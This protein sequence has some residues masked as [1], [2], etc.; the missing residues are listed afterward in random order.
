MKRLTF[1]TVMT[2]VAMTP[3]LAAAPPAPMPTLKDLQEMMQEKEYRLCVQ[4]IARLIRVPGAAEK[5]DLPGLHLMR[6]ECFIQLGDQMSAIAA[7]KLAAKSE[8][9][10]QTTEARAMVLLLTHSPKMTYQPTDAAAPP[11]DVVTIDSRKKALVALLEDEVAKIKPEVERVMKGKSLKPTM[12][13]LP[14]LIDLRALELFA[15]G[16]ESTFAAVLYPLGDHVR[17]L[18]IDEMEKIN[19]RLRQLDTLANQSVDVGGGGR[20]GRG[21]GWDGYTERRGLYTPEKNELRNIVHYLEEINETANLGLTLATFWQGKPEAWDPLVQ[22]SKE[23][24][25]FAED[26]LATN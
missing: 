4:Q 20:R 1:L 26:M 3:L 13:L 12:N 15:A 9:F 16:R 10:E 23:S 2:C 24:L 7:Y 6:G 8:K 11:I 17:Q 21:Y 25:T 5:Y 14:R 22:G 19:Q 18:M